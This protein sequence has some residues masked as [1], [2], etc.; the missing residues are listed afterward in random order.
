MSFFDSKPRSDS[1]DRNRNSRD[2]KPDSRDRKP[3]SRDQKPDSRDSN[4]QKK[5]GRYL[6]GR[7][8]RTRSQLLTVS[9]LGF[10]L[11]AAFVSGTTSRGLKHRSHD[12]TGGFLTA[13]TLLMVT[14]CLTGMTFRLPSMLIR[15]LKKIS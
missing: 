5:D 3:E 13:T 4:G 14:V 8:R 6:Q 9:G 11:A 1:R 7:G 2:P 10:F 15:S 12:R